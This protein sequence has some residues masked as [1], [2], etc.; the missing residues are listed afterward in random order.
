[1]IVI[2][3]TFILLL[4]LLFMK[5]FTD[6]DPSGTF[7][8]L[9]PPI[10][11]PFSLLFSRFL[12]PVSPIHKKGTHT[13]K[14]KESRSLGGPFFPFVIESLS[15]LIISYLASRFVHSHS[16]STAVGSHLINSSPNTPCAI[17]NPKYLFRSPINLIPFCGFE[18]YNR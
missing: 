5:L 12:F 9:G 18:E 17:S 10:F 11:I 8:V 2:N 1:V 14:K 4:L 3:S 6:L 7:L 15:I 13:Q 16:L